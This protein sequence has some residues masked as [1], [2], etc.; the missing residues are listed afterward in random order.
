MSNKYFYVHNG[1][2]VGNASID[3]SGVFTTT[4]TANATTAT[5]GPNGGA[6]QVAGGGAI[7]KDLWV[8]GALYA[9]G[10]Q[11]VTQGSQ[12]GAG[13][14]SITAGTDTAVSASTGAITIWSTAT[15]KSITSRAGGNSTDQT[16]SI[17]NTAQ[18][19]STNSG[20]ALYVAGGIGA[21]SGYFGTIQTTGAGTFGGPVTFGGNVT[22]NG[23]ATYVYSTQTAYTD[24]ILE[25]H[26][27]PG[28]VYSQWQSTDGKDIGFR[29]HYYTNS[30]DTNAALVLAQDSGA[31]EWYNTGAEST[32]SQ[33]TSA[34]YGTFK[35]GSI[36]LT[37]NSATSGA[38]TTGALQVAGGAYFGANVYVNGTVTATNFVGTITGTASLATS[39]TGGNAGYIPIQSAAGTTSFIPGGTAG[40]VL[41]YQTANT[42]TWVSTTTLVVGNANALLNAPTSTNANYYLT[43]VGANT[44]SYQTQGTV[45]TVYVNPSNG[46]LYATQ[47][48]GSG[49]GLTNVPNSALT[50][51]TITVSAGNTAIGVSGSPVS[52]GGTVTVTN[53]G[54]ASFS[55]GTTG[56]T[57]ATAT[58]GSV[59]L[60]GTLSLAS[61][62]TSATLVASPGSVVYGTASAMAFN[63]AG[64]AGNLL[65]S[66]GTS[67]P[68]FTSTSSIRVGFADTSSNAVNLIGGA[69]GG[70]PYQTGAGAT[71]FIGIGTNGYVLTSNGT[72]ATWV[73]PTSFIATTATDVGGGLAGQIPIQSAPGITTFISTGTVGQLLQMTSV[74]TASFI[75]TATL[76]VGVA[77]TATNVNGGSVSATTGVFSGVTTV[78]NTSAVS[79]T[80]T[81]ALQVAGGVGIGGGLYVGGISTFTNTVVTS[82]V[83]IVY[84]Q[85]GVAVD[86]SAVTIDT[87]AIATYRSAK[88]ILTIS[89]TGNT[90]YQ[91]TEVLVI[92]DGTTPFL[93]DVS[94]FT[95]A[96]PIMTFTV[97][98]SGGN[99]LLQ[100]TG[101][102]AGNTVKVQRIYTTV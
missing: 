8:G 41:Q 76:Q 49:A 38:S 52:L 40:Y 81:G 57:P 92:H 78:T 17:T 79:S 95:G 53:L 19:L 44:A 72:T 45:S 85:T 51:A 39:L 54:V 43:F 96:A 33:F 13:V 82:N 100:G 66:G 56:L 73:N 97:I 62:G 6:L 26:V 67:A 55:G 47:F 84:N 29:F 12:G 68:V 34:T 10:S 65:V 27:P 25:L 86:T 83:P 22:F 91:S 18:S 1:I 89:N 23:S 101:T 2:T 64:S 31:L 28:G 42:A 69:T 80:N 16:I 71:N 63:T 15:L 74:T 3:A 77:T 99:I 94:V 75:S 46:Y 36:V 37:N 59:V 9:G 90:A 30:T 58:T 35:T 98:P 7:T 24:N 14:G 4:N 60:A 61:G 21:N 11:V 70:I 93:Q 32:L 88:Y 87:F 5:V 20:N 50:S 102:A 48:N